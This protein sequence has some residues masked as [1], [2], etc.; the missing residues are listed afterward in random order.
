MSHKNDL[1]NA[2]KKFIRDRLTVVIIQ[3][4]GCSD[5]ID[6]LLWPLSLMVL[7]GLLFKVCVE[8]YHDKKQLKNNKAKATKIRKAGTK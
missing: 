2:K 1:L 4:I 7:T 8:K 3:I 6:S 5:F